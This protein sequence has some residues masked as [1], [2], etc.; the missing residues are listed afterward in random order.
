[1]TCDAQGEVICEK[2]KQKGELREFLRFLLNEEGGRLL[3]FF[4]Y[5][6]DDMKS[7]IDNLIQKVFPSLILEPQS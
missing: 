4:K 2:N 7:K 1:M 5:P 3:D 6:T